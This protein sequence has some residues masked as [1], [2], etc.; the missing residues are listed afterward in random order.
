M[1]PSKMES[2]FNLLNFSHYYFVLVEQI[3]KPL[4][5]QTQPSRHTNTNPLI[6]TRNLITPE[7]RVARRVTG[8]ESNS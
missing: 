6:K 3:R 7:G 5:C 1:E 4:I 8:D 2:N